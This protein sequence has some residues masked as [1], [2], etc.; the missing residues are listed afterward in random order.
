MK[1]KVELVKPLA[2]NIYQILLLLEKPLKYQAGQYLFVVMGENDKRP[3]SIA[4]CPQQQQGAQIELQIGGSGYSPYANEVIEKAKAAQNEGGYSFEI[5]APFGDAWYHNDD[6]KPLI[7][8]AGGTGFSYIRSILDNC[9][10]QNV[11]QPIYLYWGAKDSSQ[12]YAAQELETLAM[13]HS[14]FTYVPVLENADPNWQGRRGNVLDAVMEDFASLNA[15]DIY[16]GGPFAMSNAAR[17]MFCKL[18]DADKEHLFSDAFAFV[19]S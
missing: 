16:L 2:N 9:V 7:L 17:E 14:N 8:I 12:L 4:S 13:Q 15:Y 10:W 19:K 11:T 1:C 18:K 3:F 6:N 5:E